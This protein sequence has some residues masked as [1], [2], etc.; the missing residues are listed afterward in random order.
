MLVLVKQPDLDGGRVE[1]AQAVVAAAE[2]RGPR[3]NLD[4]PAEPHRRRD[5]ARE[6]RAAAV[7][8]AVARRDHERRWLARQHRVVD[9]RVKELVDVARAVLHRGV[10]VEAGVAPHLFLAVGHRAAHPAL[11]ARP[12]KLQVL[13]EALH[14]QSR[15]RV[16]RPRADAHVTEVDEDVDVGPRLAACHGLRVDLRAAEEIL[17]GLPQQ[18]HRGLHVLP[19]A[20]HKRER[21]VVRG[22]ARHRDARRRARHDLRQVRVALAD[23]LPQQE[24]RDVHHL[25]AAA[26]GCDRMRHGVG[27]E[28]RRLQHERLDLHL[29][30]LCTQP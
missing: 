10:D 30:L 15:E 13:R 4:I 2:G 7:P 17:E 9:L 18:R 21:A 19:P 27:D 26:V 20:L 16:A 24:R 29:R 12:A 6:R 1:R 11:V 23:D 5:A 28:R 25:L 3:A 22:L 14:L 8:V